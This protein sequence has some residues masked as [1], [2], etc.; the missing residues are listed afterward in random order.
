[1]QYRV[2]NKRKKNNPRFPLN[3]MTYIIILWLAG[4]RKFCKLITVYK[5][6]GKRRLV[7]HTR[8]IHHGN[9]CCAYSKALFQHIVWRRSRIQNI[10]YDET[11]KQT[12]NTKLFSLLGRRDVC[13]WIKRHI[14][15]NQVDEVKRHKW[16]TQ[17][18]VLMN[19]FGFYE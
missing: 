6:Q 8:I 15:E 12:E 19:Q 13:D 16:V 11:S 14:Y 1:M 18:E 4:E 5:E 17:H 7:S 9:K 3:V 10:R 2:R